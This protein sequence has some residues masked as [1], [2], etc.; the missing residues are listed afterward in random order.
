M[1]TR[2]KPENTMK[3]LSAAILLL[4]TSLSSW[5][6]SAVPQIEYQFKAVFLFNFAQ[7]VKWP[8]T[9]F[10]SA[11]API[12]IGIV[13]DDPFGQVLDETLRDEVVHNRKFIVK[14]FAASDELRGSNILFISSSEK[15]RIPAILAGLR[16][17]P[18]LTVS[19]VDE[20]CQNGG[21]INF[22]LQD[23]KVKFEVNPDAAERGG[24]KFSSKMLNLARIVKDDP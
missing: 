5:G 24:L 9:A 21:I 16:G 23:N 10:T 1:A 19:E 12:V 3:L 18:V 22:Y 7:F 17:T 4:L 6:Q 14:R 20:F 13:G 8:E 2:S 11:D 15:D